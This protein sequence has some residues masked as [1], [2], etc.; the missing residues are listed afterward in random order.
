MLKRLLSLT[1]ILCSSCGFIN[2]DELDLS[3]IPAESGM[4]LKKDQN[5]SIIFSESVDRQSFEEVFTLSSSS[6]IKDGDFSWSENSAVFYP[7]DELVPGTAYKIEIKG[8]LKTVDGRLFH[9]NI[10]LKFY[11]QTDELPVVLSSYSPD[12]AETVDTAS[13]L[14]LRFTKP[15]DSDS[16]ESQFRITPGTQYDVSWNADSTEAVIQP[17]KQWKNL[18]YYEWSLS[19]KITDQSGIPLAS[20]YRGSFLTQADLISPELTGAYPAAD[21]LDGSF[22]ILDALNLNDLAVD[23]H[24]AL[25]FSEGIS[26][27]SL[28]R[29]L[30]FSPSV[31]GYLICIDQST[32]LYYINEHLPPGTS[33]TLTLAEGIEDLSGNKSRAAE[34][35]D[36]TPDIPPLT[37]SRIQIEDSGGIPIDIIPESTSEQIIETGGLTYFFPDRMYFII[38][39]S[40]GFPEYML[41]RRSEFESLIIL[42][43]VFPPG[44]AYPAVYSSCWETDRRIRLFYEGLAESTEN[45]SVYYRL[46]INKGSEYTSTPGGSYLTEPVSFIF[47]GGAQ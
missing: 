25:N 32:F 36:F 14:R 33:C 9:K 10:I 34:R 45:Q 18:Q 24:I 13:P 6:G 41:N 37:V 47:K 5:I 28:N 1:V 38:S 11:W 20:G 12:T 8:E 16:F 39:L 3:T 4:I 46:L 26:F 23:Q 40:D 27:E 17:V 43:P 15:V 2:L 30:S 19:D 44:A 7:L 35:I 21:N 29:K 31:S 42:E 22:S